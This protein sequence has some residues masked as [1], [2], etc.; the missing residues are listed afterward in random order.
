MNQQVVD[1]IEEVVR[2]LFKKWPLRPKITISAEDAFVMVEIS[3]GKDSIFTQPSA[4][5]LLALQHLIR[6]IVRRKFPDDF[7]HLAINIGDFHQRQREALTKLA[8]AAIGRAK[9]DG[10]PVYLPPMSSF[11]RRVI[12]LQVAKESGV[13]SES[14]GTG[15][16][17][18]VVIKPSSKP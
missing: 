17:R 2:G 8:Q 18:R 5:P 10:D 14:A 9:K 11:E 15:S 3:T 13:E 1:Y 12:H 16:G 4:D 7:I 6:L